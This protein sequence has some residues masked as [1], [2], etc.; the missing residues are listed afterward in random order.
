[1][2]VQNRLDLS[3]SELAYERL[4]SAIKTGAL[5]PGGRLR[6][7]DLATRSA[8]RS[9][10]VRDA[11]RRLEANGM[12]EHRPRIGAVIR[13]LPHGEVVELYEM[14][15]VLERTAAGDEKGAGAAAQT[16]VQAAPGHRLKSMRA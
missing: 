5:R 16:H 7:T 14:R 8:L 2:T 9:T 3:H 12:I 13:V 11:F 4:C 1:M 10:S 6:E 15:L